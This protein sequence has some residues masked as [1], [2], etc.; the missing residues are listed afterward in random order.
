MRILK[1]GTETQLANVSV[2]SRNNV[3]KYHLEFQVCYYNNGVF[4]FFQIKDVLKVI[5]SALLYLSDFVKSCS[6]VHILL[7]R[8]HSWMKV[9]ALLTTP[10][11]A[12]VPV[13]N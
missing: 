6:C 2:F 3:A 11:S 7:E 5:W 13:L 8:R 12:A 10:V 9:D 4:F 1:A